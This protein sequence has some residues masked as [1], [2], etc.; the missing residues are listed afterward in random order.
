M[1]EIGIKELQANVKAVFGDLPV[2]VTKR[3]RVIGYITKD[4]QGVMKDIPQ[5]KETD[6]KYIPQE[7]E[8]AKDIPDKAKDI[9][10][11]AKD[12]PDKAITTNINPECTPVKVDDLR[13]KVKDTERKYSPM[14]RSKWAGVSAI[15]GS[16]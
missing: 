14:Y 4:I 13:A 7:N 12:I 16:G 11:K 3:G 5:T 8:V 9:P 2:A 1:R 10:D 6:A 15:R